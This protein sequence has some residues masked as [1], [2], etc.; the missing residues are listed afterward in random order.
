M[1]LKKHGD[2]AVL[3]T[4]S[5]RLP[6]ITR[7]VLSQPVASHC[8]RSIEKYPPH[9]YIHTQMIKKCPAEVLDAFQE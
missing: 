6:P 8:T 2:C 4:M 1:K 7:T 5:Y 9:I 3:F